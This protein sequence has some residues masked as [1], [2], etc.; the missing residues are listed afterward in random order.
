MFLVVHRRLDSFEGRSSL[1]TWLFGI[2]I[3]VVRNHRRLLRRKRIDD[4]VPVVDALE[5]VS[6]PESESPDAQ[7]A[8][9]EAVA[10]LYRLLDHL[11]DDQR[12]EMGCN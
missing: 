2:V 5:H 9:A 12:A 4:R 10:L 7:I 3:G 1:R 8:R 6:A 11:S